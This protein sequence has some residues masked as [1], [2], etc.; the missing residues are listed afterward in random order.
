MIIPVPEY[1]PIDRD[2]IPEFDIPDSFDLGFGVDPEDVDGPVIHC[3]G[4]EPE[5]IRIPL[6]MKSVVSEV[7]Y[8]ADE[9]DHVVHGLFDSYRQDNPDKSGEECFKMALS[10]QRF[11]VSAGVIPTETPIPSYPMSES[12]ASDPAES[13][14]L[15]AKQKRLR[16]TLEMA[17]DRWAVRVCRRN[18]RSIETLSPDDKRDLYMQLNIRVA[19]MIGKARK[20]LTIEELD[21]ALHWVQRQDL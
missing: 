21:A 11:L 17:V 8:Q 19:H 4:P 12:L 18:R 9:L 5:P 16:K 7:I 3:P 20:Y 14:T 15:V 1:I 10:A 13:E 2:G 6:G